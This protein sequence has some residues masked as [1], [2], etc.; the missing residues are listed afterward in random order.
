ML[1]LVSIVI[2]SYQNDPSH[3]KAALRSYLRQQ[4][5]KVQL[6]VSTVRGDSAVKICRRMK[7]R[8]VKNEKPG[9][10]SQLNAALPLVKG[11]WFAY[12]S[13]ND[14]A[15]PTKLI[16]EIRCC[17]NSSGRVC[18]SAFYVADANLVAQR[19]ATFYKYR[20]A[21]HLKVNFVSDL[22]LMRRE[23]LDRFKPF[24][25]EYANHAYWDFWL[26][27]AEGTTKAFVYNPKPEWIYRITN[28]SR[29]VRR[30]KDAKW[31]QRNRTARDQ[32]LAVHRKLSAR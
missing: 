15:L 30:T 2:N 5:V 24:R 20:Y 17:C 10:Y 19:T 32:M 21:Q 22:G 7:I 26:R 29:H 28:D 9:L 27:V 31:Q 12:A 16:D 6:I 14:V 13:G 25:E 4:D 18:Y 11:E 23:V 8:F 1:P 3:L